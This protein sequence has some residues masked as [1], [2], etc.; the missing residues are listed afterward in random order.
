[1]KTHRVYTSRHYTGGHGSGEKLLTGEIKRLESVIAEKD[2][3]IAQMKSYLVDALAQMRSPGN[4][5]LSE[6]AD[7]I[8]CLAEL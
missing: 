1:M 6:Y 4:V 8:R 5:S 7:S 2:A 3:K